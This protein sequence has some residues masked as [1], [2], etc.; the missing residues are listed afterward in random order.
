MRVSGLLDCLNEWNHRPIDHK[1]V[2]LS[3]WGLMLSE[4]F[5]KRSTQKVPS[6]G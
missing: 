2:C 1:F 4:L 6:H 5:A 3:G